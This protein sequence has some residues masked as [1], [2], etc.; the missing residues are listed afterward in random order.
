LDRVMLS[1]LDWGQR[2][3]GVFFVDAA[4]ASSSI[5]LV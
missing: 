2:K 4:G 3:A 5:P 1:A